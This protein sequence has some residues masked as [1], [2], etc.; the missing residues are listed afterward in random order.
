MI[1]AVHEFIVA[2]T[3]KCGRGWELPHRAWPDHR[4][5]VVR[6]G[7]GELAHDGR[8]QALRRGSVVFG[9]PGEDYA[10]RQDARRRLMLS[11]VRFQSR[12]AAHEPLA[13]KAFRPAICLQPVGFPLL[14][15]LAMQLTHA[16]PRV[17]A[18][19]DGLNAALLDALLWLL[20]D[21]AATAQASTTALAG[22]ELKPA[23][24]RLATDDE[25]PRIAALAR[26]C[27]LSPGTFRRR[28]H[29]FAGESPKR[30]LQ[31]RR[32]DRAKTLL[33]ESSYSIE[34]IAAELGYS[35]TAH[36]S[37]QFKTHTGV[38]P[39]HFRASYQ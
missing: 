28:M 31:R 39:R 15:Q 1:A 19:A 24:E 14:E 29:A 7:T 16:V 5:V 3:V 2:C 17:P 18:V 22:E 25:G 13:L 21:G 23:L 36:F 37:R 8:R 32:L 12:T 6:G 26:L 11:V 33:L 27:G 4:I 9:L 20:R 10:I 34:A 35:E 38:S 30:Y